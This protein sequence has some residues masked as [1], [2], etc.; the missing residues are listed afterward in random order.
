M[1]LTFDLL[2]PK[3][4]QHIYEPKIHPWPTF[5]EIPLTGFWDMVFIRFSGH[6]LLWP[7]PLTFWPKNFINASTNPNTAATIKIGW[8]SLQWFLRYGVHA[9]FGTH[10]L[11]HALT[12]GRT[13]PNTE[14]L[15]HRFRRWRRLKMINRR[16]II[17]VACVYASNDWRRGIQVLL[18]EQRAAAYSD[19]LQYYIAGKLYLIEISPSPN[20]L[21]S[22]RA[23]HWRLCSRVVRSVVGWHPYRE[24][25]ETGFGE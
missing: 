20:S 19:R 24:V 7:W 3:A 14:C 16:W 10:R 2:P 22:I 1:T 18:T 15:R 21:F 11:T 17:A 13:D 4:N 8:N 25:N 6:C 23:E 5:G 12:H 9:V